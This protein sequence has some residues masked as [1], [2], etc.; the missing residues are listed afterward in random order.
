MQRNNKNK[1]NS[2]LPPKRKIK[3][4]EQTKEQAPP[5]SGEWKPASYVAVTA[6]VILALALVSGTAYDLFNRWVI[7]SNVN[8]IKPDSLKIK[9]LRHHLFFCVQNLYLCPSPLTFH[10]SLDKDLTFDFFIQA[11][12]KNQHVR[13]FLV[14]YSEFRHNFATFSIEMNNF[15]LKRRRRVNLMFSFG[16]WWHSPFF[17]TLSLLFQPKRW[18]ETLHNLLE[19]VR[20]HRWVQTELIV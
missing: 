18:D 17:K 4:K 16:F 2:K 7:V 8:I 6:F 20:F 12:H 15:S 9:K 11:T 19:Y 10:N 1:N 3:H 14:W 5:L 13:A